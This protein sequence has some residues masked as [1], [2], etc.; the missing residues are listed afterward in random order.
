MTVPAARKGKV[1]AQGDSIALCRGQHAAL[2]DVAGRLRRIV[3]HPA[4]AQLLGASPR[5]D[6]VRAAEV[7]LDAGDDMAV[8]YAGRG[9]A[10]CQI[11]K[12]SVRRGSGNAIG[13]AEWKVEPGF[14]HATTV[15]GRHTVHRLTRTQ[16]LQA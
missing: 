3:D 12:A 9:G 11:A 1:T 4:N 10:A 15:C 14:D 8:V 5:S 6:I 16:G 7:T 13:L 2:Y